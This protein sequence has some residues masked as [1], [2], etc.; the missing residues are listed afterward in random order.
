MKAYES[1]Q[2]RMKAHKN[3]K[4]RMKAKQ[5]AHK[6]ILSVRSHL[7]WHTFWWYQAIHIQQPKAL[8]THIKSKKKPKSI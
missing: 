2:K 7:K 1:I 8:A 4:K 5:K 3:T 6:N